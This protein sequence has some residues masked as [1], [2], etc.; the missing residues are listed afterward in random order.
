MALE[1]R[2]EHSAAISR[3][4]RAGIRYKYLSI[5]AIVGVLTE[6]VLCEHTVK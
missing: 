5:K 6:A 1:L 2:A 3:F 4:R